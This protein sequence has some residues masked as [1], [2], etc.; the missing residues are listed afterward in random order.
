MIDGK[1]EFT[2]TVP[3]QTLNINDEF[4]NTH[5]LIE[6]G[7]KAALEAIL[8]DAAL[9]HAEAQADGTAPQ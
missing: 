6:V 3:Y 5:R 1:I 8:A 2:V 4:F 7:K 9:Q